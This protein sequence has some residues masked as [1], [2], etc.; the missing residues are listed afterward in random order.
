MVSSIFR[1]GWLGCALAFAVVAFSLGI[2]SGPGASG[3]SKPP[4]AF[5]GHGHIGNYLWWSAVEAPED[6]IE[7]GEGRIC[8]SIFFLE[9]TGPRTGEGNEVAGCSGLSA[10]T[11]ITESFVGG[12]AGLRRSAVAF[13]FVGD[14]RRI[15]L[16]RL[17]SPGESLRLRQLSPNALGEIS[18]TPISY[19]THG[20]RGA[21]CIQRLVAYDGRGEVL[22]DGGRQQCRRD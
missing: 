19:F 20:Y 11:P 3:A 14:A 16:K 18:S 4:S 6:L 15:Y 13:L 7:R 17:G 22:S 5:L 12:R 2:A 21:A 10:D 8:V 1:R 9:P